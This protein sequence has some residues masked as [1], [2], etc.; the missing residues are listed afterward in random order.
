MLVS[1]FAMWFGLRAIE[2]ARLSYPY[3]DLERRFLKLVG[4][5][6]IGAGVTL[7]AIAI[8]PLVWDLLS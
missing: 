1:F 4:T 3:D 6:C 7:A 8:K 2:S 5:L